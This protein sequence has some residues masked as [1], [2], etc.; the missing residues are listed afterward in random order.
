M[1]LGILAYGVRFGSCKK[2]KLELL[3][4]ITKCL[5]IKHPCTV[6]VLF[7]CTALGMFTVLCS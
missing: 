1:F 3:A 6:K 5:C 7:T 2:G 4:L